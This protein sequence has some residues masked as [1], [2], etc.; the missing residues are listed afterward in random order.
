MDIQQSK[1]IDA[2]NAKLLQSW[3]LNAVDTATPGNPSD[4]YGYQIEV[5][6]NFQIACTNI[7]SWIVR[8]DIK[9]EQ[10]V[11]ISTNESS[12][13]DGDAI[14]TVVFKRQSDPTMSSLKALQYHLISSVQ[15]WDQ[16]YASALEVSAIKTSEIISLTYTARNLG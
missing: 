2:H 14:L 16:Q 1:D 4:V 7:L 5:A 6:A 13:I 12:P 8:N 9:R 3:G 11:A 10:I 15:E